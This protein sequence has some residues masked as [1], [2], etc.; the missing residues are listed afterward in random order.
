M[1]NRSS[2]ARLIGL[3]QQ[4]GGVARVDAVAT[5]LG[6]SVRS[7]R[8]LRRSAGLW[9]PFPSVVG[10]PRVRASAQDLALAATLHH[11]GRTGDPSRDLVAVT[12]R[13]ALTVL[14]LQPVAPTRIELVVPASRCPRP[15][16]RCTLL[17]SE[18]LAAAEI[19]TRDRV[20][21]LSGAGLVRDLAGVRSVERLR[22]DIIE[23][24]R[25]G[26]VRLEEIDAMLRRCQRFAGRGRLR[27]VL[28]ELTAAGRV[29]SP[30][31]LEARQRF[32]AAGIIF[33]PGQV[34]VPKPPGFRGSWRMHLDL[35]I[36]ALRFGI[37]VD[38][39][40]YHSS[41]EDLRRDA[42]RANRLAALAED[43]RVIHLTW[44]DLREGWDELLALV[45][46][47]LAA[48]A[49]R[50][51]P[52]ATERG[53]VPVSDRRLAAGEGRCTCDEADAARSVVSGRGHRSSRT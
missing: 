46:S 38:S 13:S 37:E 3:L 32:R 28:A 12:R 30:L 41:P 21:V 31:E 36:A 2:L 16:P 29:D 26:L 14:G 10:L 52:V 23:L 6:C 27:R 47:V 35:G 19:V 15:G 43:W 25:R 53:A 17:R 42:E 49:A 51:G 45:T 44:A 18:H 20:P 50:L 48:Q 24:G 11:A 9:A 34:C 7:V 39:F 22:A 4:E 1:P 33:D 8:D 40:R 5:H